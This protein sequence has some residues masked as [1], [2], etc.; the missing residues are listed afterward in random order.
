MVCMIGVNQTGFTILS[1]LTIFWQMMTRWSPRSV[2]NWR[3]W[4]ATKWDQHSPITH[5]R[6]ICAIEEWS[7]FHSRIWSFDTLSQLWLQIWWTIISVQP[8]LPIDVL[9]ERSETQ[10]CWHHLPWAHGRSFV[11]GSLTVWKNSTCFFARIY[12]HFMIP[13]R[14]RI[15]LMKSAMRSEY[16]IA[17]H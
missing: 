15:L 3:I 14:M 17:H 10:C 16:R 2:K 8:V 9:A 1:S 11:S 6:P 12:R 5:P 7:T 13:Y 4:T